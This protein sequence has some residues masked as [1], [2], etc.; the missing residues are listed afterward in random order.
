VRDIAAL[1]GR[2]EISI[3]LGPVD[4]MLA[5]GAILVTGAAGS[6]G[7]EISRLIADRKPSVLVLLDRAESPL[8]RLE[9]ELRE[10][11]PTL[12]VVPALVD[13]LDQPAVT[14][15][16]NRFRPAH[17]FHAAA[18]KHVPMLERQAAE[19]VRNNV[20]GTFIVAQA[21]RAAGVERFVLISTDK[22]MRPSSVMGASKRVCEILLQ[23][24]AAHASGPPCFVTV[25]FGN[26]LDS[27]GNVVEQFARQIANGGP[28]T[29]THEAMSRYFMTAAEA[30]GLV[31]R[32]SFLGASGDVFLLD[33]DRPLRIIDLA[34]RMIHL[35]SNDHGG[36]IPIEI[37]GPRP[38]EKLQEDYRLPDLRLE[39]TESPFVL[40]ATL[41]PIDPPH[42][43]GMIRELIEVAERR[44]DAEVIRELVRIVADYE[45]SAV[46][47]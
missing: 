16:F 11:R 27:D 7:A 41:P 47:S 40:K 39:A 44:A 15:T 43:S 38:G 25:R 18:Y 45:P 37:V 10:A 3:D 17:V 6:I 14:A 20:G 24:L 19:G 8:Y 28:V 22:A 46:L 5:G 2:P 36:E 26:V 32:V 42:V 12:E 23:S 21:A 30:A 34:R 9:Q 29:V 33:I 31:L 4:A 13:I 35:A 1:L